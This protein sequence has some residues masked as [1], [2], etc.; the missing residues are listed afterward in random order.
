MLCIEIIIFSFI[1]A[2][3]TYLLY[4]EKNILIYCSVYCKFFT[5]NKSSVKKHGY[6]FVKRNDIII[7]CE[8]KKS[9]NLSISTLHTFFKFKMV[10]CKAEMSNVLEGIGLNHA[11]PPFDICIKYP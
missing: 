7:N 10:H 1:V 3:T 4:M 9:T 11:T 5:G 8:H 6:L 2:L